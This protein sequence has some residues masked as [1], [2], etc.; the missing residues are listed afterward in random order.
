MAARLLSVKPV[1]AKSIGYLKKL[2]REL[3]AVTK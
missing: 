2:L 1:P 3:N